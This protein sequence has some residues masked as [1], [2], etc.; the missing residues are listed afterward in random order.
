MRILRPAPFR[1]A[2][3]A[4]A[5]LAS[6]WATSALAVNVNFVSGSTGND[7][8]VMAE[9][10]KPWEE[11]TGNTVTIVPMPSS[12]T[13]QFAQYRLWLAAGNADVDVYMTDVIW[14]PQLADSFLDLTEAFA[15]VKDAHFPSI[16]ESQTVDGK[17]VALPFFTDAPALYYRKDL[18]DKHGSSVPA[19]WEELKATAQQ[20]MDAERAEG[21]ADIWGYVWQG[22]AYEG[23]TCNALEWIKSN[24]GGQ[25]IDP[26]GTITVNNPQAVAALEMAAS[27]VGTISPPGVLSYTEEE[28]RGVWQTGNA[29]FMRNWPYAY[30]LGNG[31]DSPI[32]GKFDVAP[33]PSGGG[34]NTSA[35]TLGGWNV[36]VSKF[37][38]NPEEATAL[39]MYMASEEYQKQ[40]AIMASHLPTIAALY[41]DAEIAEAQPLVPRWKEIFLIAVPRPSAPTKVKYNEVSSKFW[42][43]VHETLSGT[44]P[45]ADSLEILELDL[46]ELGGG[47]W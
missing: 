5:A 10:F 37:S 47:G 15:P 14:A 17:L 41:D 6:L 26:D 28:S 31:A 4:G 18:L 44:T 13:D 45:A 32:K 16:V 8:A 23:L 30:G 40:F 24:G 19:T 7:L 11:Q 12:T 3:I 35:A 43:A 38:P 39:A 34:D 1:G 20:V 9:L 29:V 42:S 27:W 21:A 25:I 22:N 33:L 46:D 36:A 2:M